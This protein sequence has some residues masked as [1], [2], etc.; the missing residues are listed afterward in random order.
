MAIIRSGSGSELLTIDP[1]SN[2]ARTLIYDSDGIVRGVKYNYGGSTATAGI[3]T[4][5]KAFGITGSSSKLVTLKR[6]SFTGIIASAVLTGA[7]T[8]AKYRSPQSGGT[9]TFLSTG[10][11]DARGGLKPTVPAV[12]YSA[13]PNV[14]LIMGF[15]GSKAFLAQPSAAS[16]ASRTAAVEWDFSN[17]GEC[18]GII[19]RGTNE[20][21]LVAHSGVAGPL[22]ACIEAEWVEE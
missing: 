20:S 1:T 15:I 14:G 10:P 4:N 11:L 22:T 13:G 21:V 2:S 3:I 18:G 17:V 12:T 6:I 16:A 7:L 8:I 5:D 19:L 9:T